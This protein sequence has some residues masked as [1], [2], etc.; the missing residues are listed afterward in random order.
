MLLGERWH[1]VSA[2][3]DTSGG[4]VLAV[5]AVELAVVLLRAGH[6]RRARRVTNPPS[7]KT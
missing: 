5:A 2:V 3:A 1:Q 7:P 6:R 4:I